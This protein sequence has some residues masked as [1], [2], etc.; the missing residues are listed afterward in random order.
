MRRLHL[1]LFLLILISCSKKE[2]KITDPVNTVV[3]INDSLRSLCFKSGS[4]WIYKSDSFPTIDCTYIEHID[5]GVSIYVFGEG[6]LEYYNIKL[7]V[8]SPNGIDSINTTI[9]TTHF[10]FMTTTFEV[11]GFLDAVL[12]SADT[13]KDWRHC[14]SKNSNIT[15][16]K[17]GENTFYDVQRSQFIPSRFQNPSFNDSS[18]FFTNSSFG[19]LKKVMHVN[20]KVQEWNLLRWNIVR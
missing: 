8:I 15:S 13:V 16:L 12:Y 6:Y 7:R 14:F 19:I 2:N 5:S 20:S 3:K 11:P 18:V 1:F 17:I 4:Y 9:G 10:L